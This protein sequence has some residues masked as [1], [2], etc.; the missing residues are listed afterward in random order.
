[1]CAAHGGKAPQ[2][3]DKAAARHQEQQ[4]M[5]LARKSIGD[6]DLSQYAD[7]YAALE[8][9]ISYGFA[10]AERLAKLVEAIPDGELRYRGKVS[11][12][13]RG[14]VTAAQT[15]LRDLRTSAAEA[16]KLGLAERRVGIQQQTMNMLDGALDLAL[17]ASGVGLD[18]RNEARQAF[19]RNIRVV[20]GEVEPDDEPA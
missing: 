2:V 3:R 4:A 17:T 9:S 1:M 7:P 14:E 16:G 8:F 6:V 19:R 5:A 11:E 20:R 13:L 12:Q 10:L 18:R 15:A